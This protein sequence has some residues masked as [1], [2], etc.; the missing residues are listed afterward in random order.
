[1]CTDPNFEAAVRN[2]SCGTNPEAMA[3]NPRCRYGSQGDG[4]HGSRGNGAE[5]TNGEITTK[6]TNRSHTAALIPYTWRTD[7]KVED[8]EAAINSMVPGLLRVVSVVKVSRVFHP[9]FSAKWRRYFYIF[10]LSHGKY[11]NDHNN[12][13]VSVLTYLRGARKSLENSILDRGETVGSLA[14]EDVKA[15][16]CGSKP[17]VF[18]ISKVNQMLQQLEGKFLSYKMFARDTKASRS[19]G[20]PMECF[21]YHARATEAKLPSH[22]EAHK[23][24]SNVL[25]V[26]LVANRFLRKMVRVLVATSLREAAAG[27][28]EDAL[29]K[30]M[31]AT[32]RRATAPPAPPEGLCLVDVGYHEEFTKE[33]ALIS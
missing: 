7:V 24:G 27:A 31:N 17:K 13:K 29:L 6:N 19:T 28:P 16:Y 1:M 26:E 33:M 2:S 22:D 8:I 4:V 15:F 23:E 25:C 14:V 12:G 20:P 18:S 3:R 30:L 9:N 5:N 32:C 21:V 10:P 11:D